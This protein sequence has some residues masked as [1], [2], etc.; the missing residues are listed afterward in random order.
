[1]PV[2]RLTGEIVFPHPKLADEDGLLAVGGDLSD[3][4][5]VLAYTYGIFPWFN[6]GEPV[7][8]W[9]PDPRCVL[10]PGDFRESKSLRQSIRRENYEF[11]FNK[12]FDEVINRC[13]NAGRKS[14]SETWITKDMKQA[15][16]S[17]NRAGYAYSV[18]TW[19]NG[20]LAGGLYGVQVGDIFSGESMFYEKKDASKSALRFLCKT[21][22]KT[23]IRIIDVQQCTNHLMSLG[24]KSVSRDD[25]LKLINVL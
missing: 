21:A 1:M 2:Y 16:K 4:R 22:D 25:Y 17:L 23:G 5:L 10:Y 19:S 18:E 9:S 6:E 12:A 11:T 20:V 3:E 24:A 8:W 15:Y 13:A 14:S 7:L